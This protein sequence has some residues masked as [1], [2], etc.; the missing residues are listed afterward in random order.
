MKSA[1]SAFGPKR[2]SLAAPHMSAFGVRADML[3]CAAMSASDPKQT[4]RKQP[5]HNRDRAIRS[6]CK[7]GNRGCRPAAP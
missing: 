2:K 4:F 1:M 3:F 5:G 6:T 7:A